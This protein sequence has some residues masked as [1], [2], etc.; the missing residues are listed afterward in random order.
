MSRFDHCHQRSY[1][2]VQ[3]VLSTCAIPRPRVQHQNFD[4]L[5][6]NLKLLQA[7][8]QAMDSQRKAKD[9]QM[10]LWAMLISGRAV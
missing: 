4:A 6:C 2:D 10:T 8:L 5:L 7:Y 3:G 9:A 1:R